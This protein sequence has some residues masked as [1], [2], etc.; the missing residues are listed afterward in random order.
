MDKGTKDISNQP[1]KSYTTEELINLLVKDYL[2]FRDTFGMLYFQRALEAL[3]AQRKTYQYPDPI[4][5]ATAFVIGGVTGALAGGL[6][7]TGMVPHYNQEVYE[8]TIHH[9]K[10]KRI[11]KATVWL[12]IHFKYK[13]S[14]AEKLINALFLEFKSRET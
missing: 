6:I 1:E 12:S 2:L 8:N 9:I 7:F 5:V 13:S 10:K 4:L 3:S 11:E 14:E